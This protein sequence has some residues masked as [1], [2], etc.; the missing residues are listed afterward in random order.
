MLEKVTE[1]LAKNYNSASREYESNMIK[2][3]PKRQLSIERIRAASGVGGSIPAYVPSGIDSSQYVLSPIIGSNKQ[4]KRKL[5]SSYN[6]HNS[7]YNSSGNTSQT[8]NDTSGDDTNHDSNADS[9]EQRWCICNEYSY[10]NMI[11][12]DNVDCPI[13]WF[14]YP[15]VGIPE[16]GISKK[17]WYCPKCKVKEKLKKKSS[18]YKKG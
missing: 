6:T 12:C 16:A 2:N 11:A 7:S 13:E 18:S 9:S 15:C 14:H 10:G 5:D 17:K 3:R 8:D 4:R 1:N